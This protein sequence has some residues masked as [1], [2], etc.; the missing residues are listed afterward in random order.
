[1]VASTG[2]NNTLSYSD[3]RIIADKLEEVCW[4]TPEGFAEYEEGWDDLKMVAWAVA[5]LGKNVTYPNVRTLR[6]EVIGATRKRRTA[7]EIAAEAKAAM[8]AKLAAIKGQSPGEQM[9]ELAL[10]LRD[11]QKELRKQ[12]LQIQTLQS[13]ILEHPKPKTE[14]EIVMRAYYPNGSDQPF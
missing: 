11:L 5:E 2:R 12:G 9:R 7:E 13:H 1:M 10:Q 3:K 8:E 6:R 14:P 4:T